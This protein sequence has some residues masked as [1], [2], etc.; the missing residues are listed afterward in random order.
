MILEVNAPLC[1]EQDGYE[2]FALTRTADLIEAEIFQAADAVIAVSRWLKDWIV[3]KGAQADRV[4][5]I[6]NGVNAKLFGPQHSGERVRAQYGLG[7]K[8]VI[9]FVGSFQPW[10]DVEGLFKAFYRLYRKDDKLRLLLV[11]DGD[12]REKFEDTARRFGVTSAVSFTRHIPHQLVPDFIGPMDVAVVPFQKMK[13]FNFSPLKLFECMAV[14]KPVVAT[15]L[16]QIAEVIEHGKTGLLYPPG[17]HQ[18][19]AERLA[20]LLYTP[21]LG[22]AIGKLARRKTLAGRTWDAIAAQTIRLALGLRHSRRRDLAPR[23]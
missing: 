23:Q 4:H 14:G 18:A 13:D 22:S 7:G 15:G 5:V 10:H 9:G 17:D 2:K 11:G 16:G 19:L 8:R 3:R 6:P 1:R 20:T 21:G 12:L